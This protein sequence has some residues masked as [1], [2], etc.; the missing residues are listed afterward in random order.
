MVDAVNPRA[1]GVAESPPSDRQ[2]KIRRVL[3]LVSFFVLMALAVWYYNDRTYGRFQQ[4]TNNAF[5]KANAVTVSPKV[6]GYV[7]EVLVAE[8]ALVRRGQLLVRI[9]AGSYHALADQSDA[10]IAVAKAS[11]DGIRA[12]IA[13]QQAA[14]G[15]T[16]GEL[17]TATADAQ[18]AAAEVAR[19]TPLVADGLETRERLDQL[20]GQVAQSRG[21]L[22]SARSAVDSAER[23][24]AT[25]RAQVRQAEAQGNAARAQR[26]ATETDVGGTAIRASV[27]G[28]IGNQSVRVGQY[29][30][31]G[32]RLLSIVPVQQVYVEANFKETQLELMRVGQ[33]VTV[34]VD[35]LP[36]VKIAGRVASISPSTGA[37]F[38]VLP[39]QNATGNFTKVVQRVPVRIEMYP[40]EATGALIIPGMS[41]AVTVD[42]RS[43]RG[44]RDAIIRSQEQRN[45]ALKR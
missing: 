9:D 12:Q 19:Y 6:A 42:T 37:Q 29:V 10:Q 16:R 34:E 14:V 45:E 13:E 25:L 44:A 36:D 2:R 39:P 40:S 20:K 41:V 27:D 21:R 3:G 5:I 32:T 38:S 11:A 22:I 43:A 18:L 33:P 1:D 28:R 31:A 30:Q 15:R 8:N 4:Q 7:E 26:R 24:V 35:A 23:R 17:Q